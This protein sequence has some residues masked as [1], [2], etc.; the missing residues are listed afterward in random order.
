NRL[1]VLSSMNN[2]NMS[3]M[4]LMEGE[5]NFLRLERALKQLIQRHDTLR[6]SFEFVDDKLVQRI[7]DHV[8]FTLE[9]M[10]GNGENEARAMMRQFIRPFDL[11]K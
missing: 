1:Y 2:Y 9:V 8:D 7:H 6:T 5:L 4:L 10:Q 3:A 11:G